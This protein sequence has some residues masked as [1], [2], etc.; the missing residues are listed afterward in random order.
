[1]SR[2]VAL[3]CA[4][5]VLT[6]GA[7][8]AN[9]QEYTVERKTS[10]ALTAYLRAHRLPLVGGQVLTGAAGKRVM[11]YG[12]VATPFGKRDAQKKAL[13][14]LKQPHLTV[15]NRIVIRPEIVQLK[16]PPAPTREPPSDASTPPSYETPPAYANAPP[17][18]SGGGQSFDQ[19]YK[20]IQ[21]Y[22]IKTP[23][24]E[25]SGYSPF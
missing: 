23:P 14:F 4:L 21:R 15:E 12:F 3:L 20:D 9:A 1:M 10:Q 5:M 22:G 24:G 16:A 13:K 19:V 6:A 17:E 18:Y 25:G 2:L 11:L 8:A 7:S